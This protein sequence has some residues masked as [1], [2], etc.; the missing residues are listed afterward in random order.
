VCYEAPEIRKFFESLGDM[1]ATGLELTALH[2]EGEVIL[3]TWK[4]VTAAGMTGRDTFRDSRRRDRRANGRV[5]RV[6]TAAQRRGWTPGLVT[7]R[8][9]R[10]VNRR[11]QDGR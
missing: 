9:A 8:D 3:L 7:S 5:Q 6:R 10:R 1:S 4:T 11:G 2:V